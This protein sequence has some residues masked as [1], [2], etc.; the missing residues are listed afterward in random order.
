VCFNLVAHFCLLLL[1][2]LK[3]VFVIYQIIASASYGRH[4]SIYVIVLWAWPRFSGNSSSPIR[5][6]GKSF[7]GKTSRVT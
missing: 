7:G 5:D 2:W 1:H 6:R 4:A 3:L